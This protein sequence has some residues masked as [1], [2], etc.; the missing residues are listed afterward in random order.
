MES[1]WLS[2]LSKNVIPFAALALLIHPSTSHLFVNRVFW[3]F[4]AYL[5]AASALPQLRV[6]QN[7]KGNGGDQI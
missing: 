6:M 5:K 2:V 4:C 1:E 3:T 7:T